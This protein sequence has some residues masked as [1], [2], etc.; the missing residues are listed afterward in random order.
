[1]KRNIYRNCESCIYSHNTIIDEKNKYEC[2]R[3]P[4]TALIRTNWTVKTAYPTVSIF[5]W[6]GEYKQI[7]DN[8]FEG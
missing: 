4:P 2:H 1:M 5:D 7:E 8:D 6:C 3:F